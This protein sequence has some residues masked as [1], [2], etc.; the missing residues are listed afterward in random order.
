[1]NHLPFKDEVF[2]KYYIIFFP[3]DVIRLMKLANFKYFPSNNRYPKKMDLVAS[4]LI[5]ITVGEKDS[6]Y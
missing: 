3:K 2:E 1:M 4:L 6:L 5:K